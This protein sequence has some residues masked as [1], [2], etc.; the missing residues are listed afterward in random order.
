MPNIS[1]LTAQFI[2]NNYLPEMQ[3]VMLDS[4]S[5]LEGFSINFYEDKYVDIISNEMT[6]DTN[7]KV[8]TVLLNLKKDIFQ[9][10]EEHDIF[11]DK[12]MLPSLT[13]LCSIAS[14]ILKVQSLEDYGFVSYRLTAHTSPKSAVVDLVDHHTD[15]T[16]IRAMEL[17]ES[18]SENFIEALKLLIQDKEQTATEPVIDIDHNKHIHQFFAYT[19]DHTSLGLR[20]Y[21]QGYQNLTLKELSQML[22]FSIQDYVD[23]NITNNFAQT[24]LDV[25]SLL[26]ITKD[27]YAT[28]HQKFK[29]SVAYL[30]YSTENVTRLDKVILQMG[31]DFSMVLD[32]NKQ[33]EL[34]NDNAS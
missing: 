24:A 30:T 2:K 18:V 20:L 1:E 29:N 14:F 12:E 8:D 6:M 23:K 21:E 3:A 31:V 28:P 22:T 19:K 5:L 10:I 11:I 17:I 9:I 7:Q 34:I 4:F 16:K 25:F 26:V 33:M 13:E 15:L 27:D 32:N